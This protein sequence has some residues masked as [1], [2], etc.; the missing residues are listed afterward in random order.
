VSGV[1]PQQQ[2]Q[3]QQQQQEELQYCNGS[4]N[5]TPQQ[6]VPQRARRGAHR[7]LVDEVWVEDVELV[8]LHHLG[9][10]V[11]GVVVR[12]V[13]LVPLVAGVDPGV[14]GWRRWLGVERRWS[15]ITVEAGAPQA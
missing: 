10:R 6:A 13:V 3:Q 4:G 14:C 5:P 7:L 15:V 9:G 12:L 2:Q 8:A 1:G 11:V